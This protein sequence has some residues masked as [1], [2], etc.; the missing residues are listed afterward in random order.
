MKK[1]LVVDDNQLV[2]KLVELY[3]GKLG[4]DVDVCNTPFGVLNKVKEYQPDVVLLDMKMPG[5]SG[6]SVAGLLKKNENGITCK[7][8]LF[9]SEDEKVQRELL[10]EGLV[11]GYFLKG[12][13]FDGLK[14]TIDRVLGTGSGATLC[15]A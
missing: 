11:D 6:R 12:P 4:C 15:E 2:G 10:E 7:T 9:S 8:V 1:V 3:L 14:E 13:S 5:L